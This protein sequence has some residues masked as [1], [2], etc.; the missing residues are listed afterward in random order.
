MGWSLGV[1]FEGSNWLIKYMLFVEWVGGLDYFF[2]CL[3]L[4]LMIV[5]SPLMS[6]QRLLLNRIEEDIQLML[7][8]GL[9]LKFFLGDVAGF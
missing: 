8:K 3:G 2:G 6:S 1:A 9:E 4:L 7:R 5:F